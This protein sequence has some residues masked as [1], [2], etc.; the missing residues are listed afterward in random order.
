MRNQTKLTE[1]QLLVMD[2]LFAGQ[3]DEQAILDKHKVSRR[4]FTKWQGQMRFIEEFNRR[5]AMLNRQR[6]L[7]IARYAPL[8]AVKLVQL[9]ESES[10]ETARKACLDIIEPH[11]AAAK[12]ERQDERQKMSEKK[13]HPLPPETASK[14]LAFLAEGK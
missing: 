9:T 12:K 1:K 6:E 7:I 4:I 11:K 13:S 8:A 3:L 14:L 5:V 10:Q 2:D